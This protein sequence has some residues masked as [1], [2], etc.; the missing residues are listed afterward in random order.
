MKINS[1]NVTI[2]VK[3]MDKTITFYEKL[4]LKLDQRWGEH[5]AMMS[6]KGLTIGIHPG[7][8]RKSSSGTVSIGFMIDKI[9]DAK[10]LL[11]KLKV[12]FKAEDDGN[13]GLYCHFKDPDGT[14]LYFVEPK[15]K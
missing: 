3:S 14:I 5:Y 11:T 8:T 7:G 13:S 15:W 9:K 1:T 4:G 12:K 2:M 6:T 10:A